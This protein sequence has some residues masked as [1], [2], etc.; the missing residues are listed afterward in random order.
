MEIRDLTFSLLFF[1][2][3]SFLSTTVHLC[4]NEP[5][6]GHLCLHACFLVF[7]VHRFRGEIG[8]TTFDA[9]VKWPKNHQEKAHVTDPILSLSLNSCISAFP[10]CSTSSSHKVSPCRMFY[11]VFPSY[12]FSHLCIC[13]LSWRLHA[14]LTIFL[15]AIAVFIFIQAV[16]LHTAHWYQCRSLEVLFSP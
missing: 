9:V 15:H 7:S 5:A 10:D 11:W 14:L 13:L 16:L 12:S 1:S 6:C 8:L 2:F 4:S 3:F